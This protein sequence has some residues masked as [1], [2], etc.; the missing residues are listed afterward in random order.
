MSKKFKGKPCV[1]C[2]SGI[3]TTADHV[4]AREFFLERHRANLPKV[5]ACD[6]CNNAKSA[7]EHYLTAIFGFGG[8]HA[9]ALENFTTAIPRRLTKNLKLRDTLVAAVNAPNANSLPIDGA[10]TEELFAF[11]ARGMAWHHWKLQLQAGHGAKATAINVRANASIEQLIF[12]QMNVAKRVP[13]D[14]GEGTFTYEGIQSASDPTLTVWKFS[15]YGGVG[16]G[17][18]KEVL[19]TQ[20]I[21]V[22]ARDAYLEKLGST[23]FKNEK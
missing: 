5:P 1:Y 8:V 4:F 23:L 17:D 12:R 9:D 20:F 6:G 14:L 18:V 10:Q 3:S 2:P 21:A 19:S 11:I 22:T 7:I 16:F 15:V 13:E